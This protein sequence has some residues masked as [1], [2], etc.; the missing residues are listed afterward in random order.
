MELYLAISIQ[1]QDY[2]E[3]EMT[4]ETLLRRG[5]RPAWHDEEIQLFTGLE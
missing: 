1:L 4:I 5:Y 3:V 2:E